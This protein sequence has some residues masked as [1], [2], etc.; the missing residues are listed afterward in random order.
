MDL[1]LEALNRFRNLLKEAQKTDLLEPTAMT[2]A[3]CDA[4][5]YPTARTVLL[6]KVDTHGF[7][8][9]TNLHSRKARQLESNPRA[10]L[11]F[12][13][14]PLMQ[15]VTIEGSVQILSDEE[16]E[17]YWNTRERDSQIVAWASNQSE[18]LDSQ[19]TLQRQHELYR[20]RF[21]DQKVPRPADWC[22]YQIV[23]QR[24]EFWKSGWH[25]LH[26]RVCYSKS[27]EGWKVTL[28]YP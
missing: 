6:K 21:K 11:C 26:E 14:Q 23:P 3:T 24:I 27:E 1:Y 19:A 28:L 5:G 2:L 25:R 12:F 9:Y 8:F 13:W 7:A 22:G 18:R 15:Q 4:R 20:D 16:A 10:A 17:A